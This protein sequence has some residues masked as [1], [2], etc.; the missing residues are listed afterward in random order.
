MVKQKYISVLKINNTVVQK[1][2]TLTVLN[3]DTQHIF[4]KL[5]ALLCQNDM[6][7]YISQWK[8][9]II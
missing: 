7:A 1:Q 9:K 5:L 8:I 4:L 2:T 6:I 3:I